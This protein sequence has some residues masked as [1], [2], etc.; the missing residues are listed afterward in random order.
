MII[1]RLSTPQVAGW[2]NFWNEM[3]RMRKQLST[4]TDQF[5]G[6]PDDQF[7]GVFPLINVTEDKDNFYVRAELPGIKAENLEIS[8]TGEN[9]AISGERRLALEGGRVKYHRR[10]REEGKFNR[11]FTVPGSIDSEKVEAKSANGVL[12]ITLPKSEKAKPRQI[13]IKSS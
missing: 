3:D 10:E 13:S 6:G 7:A 4:V 8:V 12:T 2:G 11:I 5:Y 1:R 9:V